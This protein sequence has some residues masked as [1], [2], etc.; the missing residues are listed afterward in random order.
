MCRI[1][2]LDAEAE[3]ALAEYNRTEE[4]FL[5]AKAAFS[6]AERKRNE[7]DDRLAGICAYATA[8]SRRGLLAQIRE[9]R[10]RLRP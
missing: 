6:I 4:A 10:L 9:L 8:Q 3:A 7:A 5:A 2:E 1:A